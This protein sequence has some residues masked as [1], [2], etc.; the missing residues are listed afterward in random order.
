LFR[1]LI[2]ILPESDAQ[3]NRI[4]LLYEF[5]FGPINARK[6]EK[7]LLAHERFAEASQVRLRRPRPKS[8]PERLLLARDCDRL[9]RETPALTRKALA[10][11]LGMTTSRLNQ[12]LAM[13]KP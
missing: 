2:K 3:Q 9:L 7:R 1:L 6:G 4:G 5:S 10:A 12:I 11:Q 8:V 13:L